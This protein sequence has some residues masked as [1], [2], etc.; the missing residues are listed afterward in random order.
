MNKEEIKVL[1]KIKKICLENEEC[2]TCKYYD[3]AF[4]CKFNQDMP[5]D[6]IIDE[7]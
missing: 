2:G 1:N 3:Y 5:M 4:R 6:W 7:E